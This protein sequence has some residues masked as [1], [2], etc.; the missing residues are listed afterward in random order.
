MRL[1]RSRFILLVALAFL[2]IWLGGLSGCGSK[3]AEGMLEEP[4]HVS[5][6]QQA[7]V[8]AQYQKRVQD[9]QKKKKGRASRSTSSK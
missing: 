1:L 9:R 4:E 3:P 6:E 7:E 8:K 2:P 5:A